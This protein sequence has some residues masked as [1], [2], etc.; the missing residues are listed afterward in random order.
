MSGMILTY[1]I[2]YGSTLHSSINQDR[3]KYRD[4]CVIITAILQLHPNNLIFHRPQ[5][6]H[7]CLL[8]RKQ[9]MKLHEC[10]RKS[11]ESGINKE[12]DRTVTELA[13]RC[14]QISQRC[15]HRVHHYFVHLLT[16]AKR[17]WHWKR[18]N[19]FPSIIHTNSD[20]ENAR[21]VPAL[22]QLVLNPGSHRFIIV[23]GTYFATLCSIFKKK[24]FNSFDRFFIIL[25]N[26]NIT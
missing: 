20:G 17:N 25:Y 19:L 22:R 15:C 23:T 5:N 13:E 21:K 4:N 26:V 24:D 16:T 7:L 1:G 3:S 12:K 10:N 11:R 9:K 6:H 14:R 2:G 8:T 18:K